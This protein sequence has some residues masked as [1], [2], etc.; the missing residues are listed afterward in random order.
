MAKARRGSKRLTRS[1]HWQGRITLN[2]GQRP[3]ME[4]FT[5]KMS[6]ERADELI[7][8]TASRARNENWT[9]LPRRSTGRAKVET[10]NDYFERWKAYRVAHGIRDTDTEASRFEHHVAKQ[11]SRLAVDGVTPEHLEKLV[12]SLEG[13]IRDGKLKWKTANNVWAVV[14]KMFADAK[15]CRERGL[16]VR[17]D[18]P[19][20]GVAGPDRALHVIRRKVYLYPV[21]FLQLVSC[22]A[23]PLR[24]V[25]IYTIAL[26]TYG[27]AGEQAALQCGDIDLQARTIEFV[28]QLCAKTGRVGQTKENAKYAVPIEPNLLPLL[29]MMI[30][31]VGG[32]GPLLQ[33]DTKAGEK[34]GLPRNDASE[35]LRRH[36]RMAGVTREA[37]FSEDPL[38]KPI[39]FHDLRGTAATWMALRGDAPLTIQQRVGH[40]QFSTTQGYIREAEA[41]GKGADIGVPFPPLPERLLKPRKADGNRP[42]FVHETSKPTPQTTKPPVFTG[43]FR[44]GRTGLEPAA[45]GVTGRRYN[46]LNYRPKRYSSKRLVVMLEGP[47]LVKTVQKKSSPPLPLTLT[48][49]A[50]DDGSI[51]PSAGRSAH[52]GSK[53]RSARSILRLAPHRRRH[54]RRRTLPPRLRSRRVLHRP[55]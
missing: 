4:P 7:E 32:K 18:N 1:G 8:E 9:E 49:T 55:R 19:A 23:V 47:R 11:I 24:W 34:H 35:K 14:A 22:E 6:A 36:L 46:Q 5:R 17:A 37:L 45:S 3:W 12:V 10:V 21:E 41:V 44:A 13:K 40:R 50:P 25:R 38:R 15:G 26:F 51:R 30:E 33:A 20:A 16:R 28:K 54:H 52:D 42:P 43:G 2:N 39:T 53:A 48:T 31:E 29:E 27:R